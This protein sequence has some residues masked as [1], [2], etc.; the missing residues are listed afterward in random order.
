MLYEFRSDA[1]ENLAG[2]E[3]AFRT[4]L[5]HWEGQGG[6]FEVELLGVRPGNGPLDKDAMDALP[7]IRWMSSGPSP[8]RNPAWRPAPPTAISPSLWASQPIP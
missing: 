3:A 2:M 7:P 8:G 1:Q 5:T 6:R 4:A